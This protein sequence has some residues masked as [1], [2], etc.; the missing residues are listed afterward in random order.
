MNPYNMNAVTLTL[1]TLDNAE[2]IKHLQPFRG[3]ANIKSISLTFAKAVTLSN[4]NISFV[5]MLRSFIPY[6]FPRISK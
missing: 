5:C 3:T 4:T 6:P 1:A 2:E